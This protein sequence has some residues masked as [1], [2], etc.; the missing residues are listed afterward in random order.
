MFG[1]MKY[2]YLYLH[3]HLFNNTNKN[4]IMKAKNYF[5]VY[6][7]GSAVFQSTD[8][9]T[10]YAYANTYNTA[11]VKKSSKYIQF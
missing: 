9:L 3:C 1:S 7:F 11:I 6:W 5:T 10:A 2:I 8:E 4:Y